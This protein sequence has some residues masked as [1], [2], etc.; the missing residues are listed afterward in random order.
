METF[1]KYMVAR[2]GKAHGQVLILKPPP[3]CVPI[4][5]EDAIL[6]A[7]WLLM[8]SADPGEAVIEIAAEIIARLE[9]A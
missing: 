1:N 8:V 2:G 3:A 4:S 9:G 7:G 5:K 6:F